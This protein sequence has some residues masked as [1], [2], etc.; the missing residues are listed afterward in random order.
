MGFYEIPVVCQRCGR[1]TPLRVC[2]WC[3]A[4]LFEVFE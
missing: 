4:N 3:N 1:V 2:I